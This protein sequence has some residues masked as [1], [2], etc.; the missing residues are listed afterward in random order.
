[1]EHPNSFGLYIC[2]F[3]GV[4]GFDKN[5]AGIHQESRPE[6][7]YLSSLFRLISSYF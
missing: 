3:S 2:G 1:M 7:I 4:L 6:L 5:A